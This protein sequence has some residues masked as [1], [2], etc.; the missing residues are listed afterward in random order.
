MVSEWSNFTVKQLVLMQNWVHMEDFSACAT[1]S[2]DGRQNKSQKDAPAVLTLADGLVLTNVAPG[3]VQA[4]L[5]S[6]GKHE[7]S[8][9]SSF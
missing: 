9:E 1:S 5:W 2:Q 4:G 6:S 7:H 3:W 8:Q